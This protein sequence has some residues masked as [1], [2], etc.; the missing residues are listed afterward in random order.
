MKY[1]MPS[2]AVTNPEY[3]D[4][5]SDLTSRIIAK[6]FHTMCKPYMEKVVVDNEVFA[7]LPS[8]KDIATNIS[9]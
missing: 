8:M 1:D 3:E 5:F 2:D 9:Y 4:W 7:S 6:Q